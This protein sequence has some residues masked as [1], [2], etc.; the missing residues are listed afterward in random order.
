M[1]VSSVAV[2]R[3]GVM[4]L[5]SFLQSR[6]DGPGT[7]QVPSAVARV[8]GRSGRVEARTGDRRRVEGGGGDPAVRRQRSPREAPEW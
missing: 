7:A 3:A 5:W 1:T 6:A 2:G 4:V 8:M